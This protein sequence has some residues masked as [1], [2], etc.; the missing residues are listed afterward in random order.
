MQPPRY[1]TVV[2]VI[3]R[4]PATPGRVVHI[5]VP[6]MSDTPTLYVLNVAAVTKPHAVQHLA[7]DLTGYQVH[8]AVI[9]ET[10]LKKKHD[11]QLF[12][13]DGYTLFRRDRVGRRLRRGGSVTVYVSNRYQAT[14][15]V[16]PGDTSEN[17]YKLL[18]VLVEYSSRDILI[19]ALYHP[20]KPAYKQSALLDHIEN[21]VDV[22]STTFPEASVMLAG[23]FNS[24]CSNDII[25]R[26]TLTSIV[27]QPMRGTSNLDRIYVSELNYVNVKVIMSATTRLSSLTRGHTSQPTTND[28]N[29]VLESV[30]QHSTLFFSSTYRRRGLNYRAMPMRRATLMTCAPS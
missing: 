13:I 7:A 23:D 5:A 10:H 28:E 21:C 30:R 2:D 3:K 29:A 22:L 8:I 1:A 15:W 17:S 14:T 25:T 20:P 11:D 24:L 6:D 27:D 16:C 4:S 26:R 9:S 12:V 19:G 18:W